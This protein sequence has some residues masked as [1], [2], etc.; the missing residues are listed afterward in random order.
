M[1]YTLCIAEDFVPSVLTAQEGQGSAGGDA[2]GN[3]IV[4]SVA[5]ALHIVDDMASV[6]IM[7]LEKLFYIFHELFI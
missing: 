5:H 2:G 7:C 6:S 1:F 3:R 4:H